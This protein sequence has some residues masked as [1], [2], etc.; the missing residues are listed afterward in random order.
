MKK[1]TTT[2]SFLLYKLYTLPQ[3]FAQN[4]NV[5]ELLAPPAEAPTEVS[6]GYDQIQAVQDLPDVTLEGAVGT[7]IQTVLG[8]TMVI[9]L[10]AIVTS[11]IYM[12]IFEG[13]EEKITRAK[14]ILAYLVYGMAIVAAAYG[15]VSGLVRIRFF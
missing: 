11:G 12:L 6:G 1:L 15:V 4:I 10:A 2:L 7:A 8:W 14:N 9:A 3:T 13:E 5:N